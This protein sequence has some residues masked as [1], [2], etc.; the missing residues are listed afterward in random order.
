MRYNPHEY[1]RRASAWVVDHD[2]C[3]LFLDMGLGKSV[4][5][6]TAISD[7]MDSCDVTR[8]LVVAPKK[9]AETTWSDEA[10]KWDH[11]SHLRVSRVIGDAKRRMSALEADADIYVISRDSLVWLVGHY[12]GSL[13]FD[14]IVIDELTSFK[15]SRSQRFKAMRIATASAS[16]VVG[17]TGTS[18]PNVLIDLWGELYWID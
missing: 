14:M 1:Q 16:R 13:P 10:E 9:V 5:T 15:S 11:L 6:L 2:R 7:L 3:C 8:T 12:N 4:I 18:A 17:L